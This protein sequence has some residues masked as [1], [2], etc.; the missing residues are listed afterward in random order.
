MEPGQ[1]IHISDDAQLAGKYDDLFVIDCPKFAA[2]L[3]AGEKITL[4]YGTIELEVQRFVS[5]A[6]F[7]EER[8]DLE[9]SEE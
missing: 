3:R 6:Q 9:I 8:S 1:E 2:K 7:I 5:K 4:N